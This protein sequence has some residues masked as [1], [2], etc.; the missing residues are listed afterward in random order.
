[1]IRVGGESVH[2]IQHNSMLDPHEQPRIRPPEQMLGAWCNQPQCKHQQRLRC[3]II[4]PLFTGLLQREADNA[5]V[6]LQTYPRSPTRSNCPGR[7]SIHPGASS[8]CS[9]QIPSCPLIRQWAPSPCWTCWTCGTDG[10]PDGASEM[11]A[12]LLPGNCDQ[13]IMNTRYEAC[14]TANS[15]QNTIVIQS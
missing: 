10:H 9:H 1:M 15:N 4:G 13:K 2:Q 3:F 11:S 7:S 8:L 12:P 5:H 14:A 6:Y